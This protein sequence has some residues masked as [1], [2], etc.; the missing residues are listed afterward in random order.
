M[1]V[2]NFKVLLLG[3]LMFFIGCDKKYY[4]NDKK[5]EDTSTKQ[6]ERFHSS[7]GQDSNKETF[8]F[9]NIIHRK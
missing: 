6:S 8:E 5:E 9:S 4:T 7:S 3:I 2:I 1:K